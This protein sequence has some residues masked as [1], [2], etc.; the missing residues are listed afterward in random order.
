MK[1]SERFRGILCLAVFAVV[2]LALTVGSYVRE[3]ATWDEPQ[4]LTAGYSALKFH[5]YRTDP[6]HPPFIRMWAALPLLG[7]NGIKMDLQ[8]IDPV[9]SASWVM[10]GQFLFCHD[11]LYVFND[12]DRLLY[13]ARFMI[14]L[15]GVLL[16]VLLFYWSREL[17]GFWPA[18]VVLGFYTIEPNILANCRLV[19][20][21][22]GVACFAFGV[23]YFLWRTA[24]RLS[25]GNLLGLV[26]FFALAQS[27]KFSAVLLGPVVLALLVARACQKSTWPVRIG[28]WTE[29]STR[30]KRLSAVAVIFATLAIAAW[31][32]IWAAY[33]FRYLP[34]AA[35]EWRME[36]HNDPGILKR[37]PTLASVIAWVDEHHLLPNAY[38]EGFLL[39][40]AKAQ[41]RSGFLAGS[42][43]TDGWWWFFP[44]AFLI[45]TP[46]S[47]IVLFGAGVI[48]AAS[49][50][51]RLVDDA[52]Y[53]LLPLVTFLV[54]AMLA[55]LNIGLRHILP[56]YPFA[57]LLSGYAIT[58][59]CAQRP[60]PL[61]LTLA[62]LCLLALG[63]FV[64]VCPHYLAFFNQFVGGPRN[65]HEYLV[66]SNLDWGQDLKGL[67]L[68]M[69]QH[70][71]HHINLSY[72]GTADADYYKI[73]CTYLPGGPF[74]DTKR[75]SGPILPGFVAV[76]ASNLR[77]LYFPANERDEY[78]PLL[79]MEPAAVIGYSIYVYRVDHPWWR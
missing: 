16:G 47:V 30:W 36:L 26:A 22:F 38:N 10:G 15:L 3:S 75:Q 79:D 65:G 23:A 24:R 20:T 59:L 13:A 54:A 17:F 19:T 32:A 40:Q 2:F 4:H 43:R 76:S 56:V 21:D 34:S 35:P 37:T 66:D 67:K 42:Y 61:R 70:D 72:F 45:K 49:R 68:W 18:V 11:M 50:W 63:E 78:K 25:A 8:R 57:L 55:K 51:R 12:A 58:K 29:L 69:D 77:G 33:D 31:V 7:M 64:T 71:V 1:V 27:S 44:F 14:V 74:F 62:V 39:G 28:R 60:S 52:I 6:E 53:A 9:A 5:D 46:I 73:D 48:L 41:K